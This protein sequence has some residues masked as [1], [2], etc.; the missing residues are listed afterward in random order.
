MV[1]HQNPEKF[2]RVRGGKMN[3][4]LFAVFLIGLGVDSA[5]AGHHPPA[6]AQE[7]GE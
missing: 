5:R 7:N 4:A 3:K 1:K 6:A 2:N